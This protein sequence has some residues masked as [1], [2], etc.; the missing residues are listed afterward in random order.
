MFT[1]TRY[2]GIGEKPTVVLINH[3]YSG[4][5]K[6]NSIE[7]LHD[8]LKERSEKIYFTADKNDNRIVNID[9]WNDTCIEAGF[10]LQQNNFDDYIMKLKNFISSPNFSSE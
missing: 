5:I 10:L 4:G 9:T 8:K 3:S 2:T 6:C 1:I 7:E